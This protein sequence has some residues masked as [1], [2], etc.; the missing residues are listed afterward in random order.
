VNDTL[1]IGLGNPLMGDDGIGWN[2]AEALAVDPPEGVDVEFGGTDTLRLLDR[3]SA[4]RNVFLVDATANGQPGDVTVWTGV[5]QPSRNAHHL[6]VTESIEMLK[7]MLPDTRITLIVVGI[8]GVRI[9]DST[10]DPGPIAARV[11]RVIEDGR[12]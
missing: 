8:E 2:V 1:V 12:G 6:S 11:R 4:R 9:G 10:L 7:L 5:P 3:M